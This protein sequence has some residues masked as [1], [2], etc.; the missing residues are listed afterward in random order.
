MGYGAG[1]FTMFDDKFNN[2]ATPGF[3]IGDST[4]V[5]YWGPNSDYP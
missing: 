3:Y 4:G 1:I 5:N 2:E